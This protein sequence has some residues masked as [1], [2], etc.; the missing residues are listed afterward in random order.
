MY[1]GKQSCVLEWSFHYFKLVRHT[2]L[3][4]ALEMCCFNGFSQRFVLW[5]WNGSHANLCNGTSLF[6]GNLPMFSP[7]IIYKY[8]SC[9][10]PYIILFLFLCGKWYSLVFKDYRKY[11]LNQMFLFSACC[12]CFE[13]CLLLLFVKL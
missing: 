7:V 13:D 9:L 2:G 11:F 8:A 10:I 12:D 4:T 6:H 5:I 3:G 1:K